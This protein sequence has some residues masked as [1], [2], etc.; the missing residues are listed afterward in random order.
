MT[1][2]PTAEAHAPLSMPTDLPFRLEVHGAEW[3]GLSYRLVTATHSASA[4]GRGGD[5]VT[6]TTDRRNHPTLMIGDLC[7]HSSE[8]EP[9]ARVL[10]ESLRVAARR[11][12]RPSAILDQAAYAMGADDDKTIMAT[13]AVCRLSLRRHHVATTVALAGHP[14]ALLV[15][16]SGA[17]SVVGTPGTCF[18]E[19]LDPD[20]HDHRFTLGAGDVVA[21]FTD[22]ITEAHLPGGEQFGL[23][24]L[25]AAL[26]RP[27][28]S[29][30]GQ[31]LH[32]LDDLTLFAPDLEDATLAV[33]G[34]LG[35]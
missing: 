16:V 26:R 24:R 12:R 25:A 4:A 2:L 34:V 28:A 29:V 27:S 21:F 14:P 32:V 9:A 19:G 31:V 22:G 35:P 5:F 18:C 7:G 6:L 15:R 8:L 1:M 17:T 13:A 11:R 30:E 10:Q 3:S 33:L 23:D 20:R